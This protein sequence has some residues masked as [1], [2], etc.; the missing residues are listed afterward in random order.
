M[1]RGG[2]GKYAQIIINK[3]GK[4]NCE[5]LLATKIS[6]PSKG[7]SS[8]NNFADLHNASVKLLTAA[9]SKSINLLST[10]WACITT[11]FAVE[12]YHWN[13]SVVKNHWTWNLLNRYKFLPDLQRF[14]LLDI[15]KY[16]ENG[17]E[18]SRMTSKSVLFSERERHE[19]LYVWR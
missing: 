5:V 8:W 9:N 16:I 13:L 19:A 11:L 14:G 2:Q 17:P 10:Y 12:P 15:N 4:Q 3:N 7:H 18:C 6:L 1:R